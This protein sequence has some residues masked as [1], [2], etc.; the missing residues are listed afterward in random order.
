MKQIAVIL[1]LLLCLSACGAKNQET[2]V[3]PVQND[4]ADTQT[5]EQS[6]E[7]ADAETAQ[8]ENTEGETAQP[9]NAE[10]ETAQPENAETENTGAETAAAVP[11]ITF[12][13][14]PETVSA[15]DGTD[16]LNTDYP[17]FT[18]TIPGNDAAAQR[19]SE[20]LAAEVAGYREN[21]AHGMSGESESLAADAL[22][23][24]QYHKDEGV[25][26]TPY[27][28][29]LSA[30]ILRCDQQVLCV[31]FGSY[32][33]TGGVHGLFYTF[34]R[35]YDVT[36]GELLTLENLAE[37]GVNLKQVMEEKVSEMSHNPELYD[38]DMF[39]EGYEEF[40]PGVVC[41]D[42][43]LNE[44]GITFSAAPYVL[45]AYAAGQID[46]TIPY[47]QLAGLVQSQYLPG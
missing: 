7:T 11:Q 21:L 19:I 41:D 35:C 47:D 38:Q 20:S 43:T 17:V 31:N 22:E 13:Q 30:E 39:F 36:T 24:Y 3:T 44:N 16:V 25:D 8:P 27:A 1:A 33:Y 37:E 46:F 4:S 18:V 15:E 32:I 5:Q 40:L 26:W 9:E 45:A 2:T 14:Q 28:D 34:G 12:E 42:F 23:D 29:Q 10:S 6:A